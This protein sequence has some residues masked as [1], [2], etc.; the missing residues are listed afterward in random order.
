M[1]S[2]QQLVDE[3]CA[4]LEEAN[5]LKVEDSNLSKEAD[6]NLLEQE[7]MKKTGADE[8][9][10]RG[11][12][13]SGR[14]DEVSGRGDEEGHEEKEENEG[15][16]GELTVERDGEVRVADEM[17]V[18]GSRDRHTAVG[19]EEENTL[20]E[21]NEIGRD[22]N[23][24]AIEEELQQHQQQRLQ[25][26]GA[27]VDEEQEEEEGYEEEDDEEEE[28]QEEEEEGGEDEGE[29]DEAWKEAA[30]VAWQLDQ[31]RDSMRKIN[32][33]LAR[34]QR[35]VLSPSDHLIFIPAH[36]IFMYK[37]RPF[38]YSYINPCHADS[39]IDFFYFFSTY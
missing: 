4:Q 32:G 8:E 20:R 2:I 22:H 11:D 16:K 38:R 21:G 10:G 6:S 27:N 30:S 7:G 9:R 35:G 31:L 18:R 29:G 25:D 12:E 3:R 13:D 14:G 36:L 23:D 26:I 17:L 5:L 19:G 15:G 34:A 1:V 28:E 24:T 37:S 39:D 33:Y